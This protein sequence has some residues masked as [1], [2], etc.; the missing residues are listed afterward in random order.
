MD[1]PL[2]TNK[3]QAVCDWVLEKIHWQVYLPGQRIP[4]VR[5]LAQKLSVS[6]FTVAQA[7]DQ[8]TAHGHLTA[9]RG[10]GYFV[11]VRHNPQPPQRQ[12]QTLEKLT[13]DVLE[14][15]WLL[16]HLFSDYP[17]ARNPGSG[18]LP[19]SWTQLDGM[20]AAMRKVAN[21]L[22]DFIYCYG[23]AQG[24]QPL[25]EVFARQL[26][27]LGVRAKPENMV[28]TAGISGAFELV[29]NYLVQ[30]GDTVIVDDPCWF[31]IIGCLQQK[32]IRVLG[33]ARNHDGPDIAQLEKILTHEKPKLYITNSVLH[34]PTS[35]NI[36]PAV[37]YQV[38][39]LMRQH[40]VYLFEDDVY[41]HFNSGVPALRYAALDQF[42][43]VFYAG[44]PSKIMGGNWRVGLLCCPETHTEGIIRQKLLSN[45]ATPELT[46]RGVYQLWTASHYRKHVANIHSKLH[47]AHEQLRPKLENIGIAYPKHAQAGLLIWIDT[48]KDTVEMALAAHKAGWLIAPG[49]LFSPHPKPSTFMRL[50]VA[51]CS[52]AFLAWL[53]AWQ[54]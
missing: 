31:W 3:T 6:T 11:N 12:H 27:A 30:A 49:H 39:N 7:Y 21:Q 20:Q 48:G 1:K 50:N 22:D 37:A 13:N 47:K 33:V 9:V 2:K 53:D 29:L 26:D 46:E 28:T 8:L 17:E 32:G 4:S 24:Y 45:M 44:G 15:T 18:Q 16:G 52:D 14:T 10:S 42:E 23:H 25:R 51:T 19:Q 34:N 38:L 43:R 36:H 41:G 5:A 54:A 35:F 40:H